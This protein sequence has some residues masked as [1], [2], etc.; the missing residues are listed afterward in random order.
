MWLVFQWDS[1][2]DYAN[3][4]ELNRSTRLLIGFRYTV[5]T[6]L[7]KSDFSSTSCLYKCTILNEAHVKRNLKLKRRKWDILAV[8]FLS[9]KIHTFI[10]W[11]WSDLCC[12]R[13]FGDKICWWQNMFVAKFVGDEFRTHECQLQSNC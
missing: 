13:G 10:M 3:L 6:Q 4:T 9:V 12:W 1:T 8:C 2:G 7:W 11:T 5:Y